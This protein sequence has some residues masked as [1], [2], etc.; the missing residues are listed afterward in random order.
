MK[1]TLK[2]KKTWTKPVVLV[3]NIR[4]DTFSGSGF[5]AEGAGKNMPKKV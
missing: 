3:L 1:N 2:L 5:G 4:K